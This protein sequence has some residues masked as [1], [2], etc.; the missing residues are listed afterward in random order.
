MPLK[1][2]RP[3]SPGVRA[4]VRPDFA[5]LTTRTPY[6]PLTIGKHHTGGRNVRGKMTVRHRG[7]GAKQSWRRV[8]FKRDKVGIPCKVETIEY[9][10]AAVHAGAHRDEGQRQADV[11]AKCRHS[12]R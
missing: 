4:A 6:K 3:T 10:R 7:G 1:R 5:E 9:D 2:L 12:S 11:G 8:D